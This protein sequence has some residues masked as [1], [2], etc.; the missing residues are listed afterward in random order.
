MRSDKAVFMKLLLQSAYAAA[1]TEG[2]F[3][4]RNVINYVMPVTF[5][6][7][8]ILDTKRLPAL[9][10][11]F[12]NNIFILPDKQKQCRF[13]LDNDLSCADRGI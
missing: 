13:L 10:L 11:V 8:Y 7:Q 4:F 5:H 1:Y 12:Q 2:M 3:S 6:I 9:F